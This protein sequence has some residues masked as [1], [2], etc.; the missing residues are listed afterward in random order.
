MISC[1]EL[2]WADLFVLLVSMRKDID[3]SEVEAICNYEMKKNVI[4][5]EMI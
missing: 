2:L 1:A 5:C 4:Y 3:I